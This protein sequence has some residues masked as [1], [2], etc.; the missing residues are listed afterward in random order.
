MVAPPAEYDDYGIPWQEQTQLVGDVL[1]R[2]D[3]AEAIVADTEQLIADAAAGHPELA[4]ATTV[5]ASAAE[6]IYVYSPQSAVSRVL[7]DLGLVVPEALVDLVGDGFGAEVSL[8]QVDLVDLDV[9]LWLDAADDLPPFTVD[10][11]TSLPVSTE[12]REVRLA[13][14]GSLAGGSFISVLSLP[15]ILEQ[16]VPMLAAAVDGDPSTE[17]P[18]E[19]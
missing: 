2:S 13:T 19:A 3:E 17:V 5:V 1:G 16:L 14:D 10:A 15:V 4:G 12:G 8:E 18:A 9:V 11:Y 7:T 6:G